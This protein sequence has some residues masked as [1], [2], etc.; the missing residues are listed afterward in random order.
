MSARGRRPYFKIALNGIA[1]PSENYIKLE[2]GVIVVNVEYDTDK[3]LVD[4][5]LDEPELKS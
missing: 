5:H 4:R 2:Y 3:M 1:W